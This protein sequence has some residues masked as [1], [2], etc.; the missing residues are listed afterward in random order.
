MIMSG[1]S[2]LLQEIEA[3]EAIYGEDLTFPN[4]FTEKYKLQSLWE[5]FEFNDT[6]ESDIILQE[7]LQRKSVTLR[8]KLT[9]SEQESSSSFLVLGIILPGLYLTDL[10]AIPMVWVEDKSTS[11]QVTGSMAFGN[12]P[13]DELQKYV[14]EFAVSQET[15]S[16]SQKMLMNI[17][18]K[19][20]ELAQDIAGSQKIEDTAVHKV[21]S[22]NNDQYLAESLQALEIGRAESLVPSS[23]DDDKDCNYDFDYKSATWQNTAIQQ[24]FNLPTQKLQ[25]GRRVFYLHHILA[26]SKRQAIQQYALQL[27]LSGCSKI[28]YPGV[29]L[30]EGDERACSIYVDAISKMRWK[31]FCVRG[32]EI[33]DVENEMEKKRKLPL[34]SF[35]EFGPDEMGK[36]AEYCRG[37]GLEEL[38][39]TCMKIYSSGGDGGGNGTIGSKKKLGPV[40]TLNTKKK[41]RK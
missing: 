3:L 26:T 2:R 22:V 23:E 25:L 20:I 18:Q 11:K 36:I 6:S 15:D 21:E 5:E 17:V 10:K 31:Q 32:E 8:I 29:I 12:F 40:S 35:I 39:K 37:Y 24:N 41:G 28:G 34:K 14:E 16:E 13:H 38:F 9:N 1:L 33:I 30:I 7:K 4:G 27:N 19:A